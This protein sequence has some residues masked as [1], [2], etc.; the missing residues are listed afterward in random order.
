[1]KQKIEQNEPEKKMLSTAECDESPG[2]RC[3]DETKSP[4]HFI[5]ASRVPPR[6]PR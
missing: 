1:M 5:F 4:S 6:C 2:K 3:S